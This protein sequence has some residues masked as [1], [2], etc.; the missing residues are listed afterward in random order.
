VKRSSKRRS[1]TK[2]GIKE[3]PPPLQKFVLVIAISNCLLLLFELLK[4]EK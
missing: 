4:R 2:T 1:S 3:K